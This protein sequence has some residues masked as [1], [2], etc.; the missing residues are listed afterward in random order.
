MGPSEEEPDEPG[1]VHDEGRRDKPWPPPDD[2]LWRHPS[3]VRA[4]PTAS[5]A[6]PVARLAR[7]PEGRHW[8]VGLAS[9]C[10]GALVVAVVFLASG[11]VP[12]RAPLVT[13]SRQA[14]QVS[15]PR[16]SV[17]GGITSL[18]ELVDPSIVGVTVNGP[19]G[20]VTGSGV[21]VN[22]VGDESY[23]LTD[24]AQFSGSASQVQVTSSWGSVVAARLVG[25]DPASGVAL[26]K[27]VIGPS[28]EV[29]AANPGSV[30]NMQDGEE[31]VAVGSQYMAGSNSGPNFTIGYISDT[32]SYIQ[33]V[34]GATDG[35]FSL[36]PASMSVSP[37]AY[38]G[39]VVDTNGNVLG[40]V[41]PVPGQSATAG[42]TYMAPID[43]AIAD[44]AAMMKDGQ[45]PAHPWL[46]VLDATDVS[47]PRAR[48]L[49]I[50]GP[51]AVESVA[52]GSPAARAGIADNDVVTSLDGRP[53]MSVGN[54]IAWLA[55]AKPGEVVTVGWRSGDRERA[56]NITLGT[57]PAAA[58][59][60]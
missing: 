55:G 12:E 29:T 60:S 47:G 32:E 18:L 13:S 31:V 21:I 43:T 58:T 45:V 44:E 54:L 11:A 39:A 27:A 53:V 22:T 37:W 56:A 14:P 49:G 26:L 25:T 4:N 19:Q 42:L 52:A 48:A 38:G 36:L 16:T 57:E 23:I 5:L 10:F 3:E 34:N 8:L 28:G 33:P 50:D 40:I 35:L 20:E 17:A 6:H 24:S 1:G 46:G 41:V 7:S 15:S 51:V 2:R 9:G 30:A 59:P